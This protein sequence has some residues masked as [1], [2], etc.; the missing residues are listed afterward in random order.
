MPICHIQALITAPWLKQLG[1][2]I[3]IS[4]VSPPNKRAVALSTYAHAVLRRRT[5]SSIDG[6]AL[7]RP[8]EELV[9]PLDSGRMPPGSVP[10][11]LTEPAVAVVVASAPRRG[12][13][14]TYRDLCCRSDDVTGV[15]SKFHELVLSAGPLV[16]IAP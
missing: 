6:A 2:F 15:L 11:E 10:F 5:S 12:G 4:T 8:G 3:L 1:L 7:Q 13:L 9:R 14:V 16:I